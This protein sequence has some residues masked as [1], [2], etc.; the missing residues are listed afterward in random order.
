MARL[1]MLAPDE[2]RYLTSTYVAA[3]SEH[4]QHDQK[5]AMKNA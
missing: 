1:A 4:G 2:A 5:R 3:A